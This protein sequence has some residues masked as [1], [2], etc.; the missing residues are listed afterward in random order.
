[1][2]HEIHKL[3]TFVNY[4][5]NVPSKEKV[6]CKIFFFFFFF[7]AEK[8]MEGDIGIYLEKLDSVVFV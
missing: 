8:Y 2:L 3:V 6:M 5:S 4:N 7:Y 1:M